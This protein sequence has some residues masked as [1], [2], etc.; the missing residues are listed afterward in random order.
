VHDSLARLRVLVAR[1]LENGLFDRLKVRRRLVVAASLRPALRAHCRESHVDTSVGQL[2]DH[3]LPVVGVRE[4]APAFHHLM[5]VRRL[6]LG[7]W[8]P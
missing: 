3:E 2:L 5:H 4:D 8:N 1:L 7:I 6:A